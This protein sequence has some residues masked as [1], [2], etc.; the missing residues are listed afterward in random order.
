MVIK[1]EQLEK[2]WEEVNKKRILKLKDDLNR[3]H[4]KS[5]LSSLEK[6]IEKEKA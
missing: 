3:I 2:R 4:I 5:D 6:L 1:G